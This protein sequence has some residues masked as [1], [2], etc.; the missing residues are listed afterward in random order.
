MGG[1]AIEAFTGVSRPHEDIDIELLRADLAE[2]RA[3]VDSRYHLWSVS[4]GALTPL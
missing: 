4:D 1:R 2:F 3:P